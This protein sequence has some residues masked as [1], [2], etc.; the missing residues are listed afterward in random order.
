M[1]GLGAAGHDFPPIVEV[2]DL[3]PKTRRRKLADSCH[4]LRTLDTTYKKHK[5]LFPQPISIKALEI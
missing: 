1:H 5:R 4:E 2:L 3:P